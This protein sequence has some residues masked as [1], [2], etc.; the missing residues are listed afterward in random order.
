LTRDVA[1]TEI[2]SDRNFEHSEKQKSPKMSF[3]LNVSDVNAEH[4]EKQKLTGDFTDAGIESVD[5][6][7][8]PKNQN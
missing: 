7:A 6:V 2:I 8:H 4:P 5:N 3:M 1:D